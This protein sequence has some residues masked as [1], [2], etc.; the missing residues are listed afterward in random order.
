MIFEE[1]KHSEPNAARRYIVYHTD[2][3]VVYKTDN[4]KEL[5][6]EVFNFMMKSI[7]YN[8]TTVYFGGVL[9]MH[10]HITS[11]IHSK[12]RSENERVKAAVIKRFRKHGYKIKVLHGF[13]GALLISY[14]KRGQNE[15]R[16][17]T[18]N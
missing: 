6:Y 8:S 14:E 12:E 16:E 4:I 2:K 1:I 17:I 18:I 7:R 3:Q 11:F 5:P 9:Y 15:K 10:K 13:S